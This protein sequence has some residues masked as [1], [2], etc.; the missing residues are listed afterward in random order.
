MGG[1]V[2]AEGAHAARIVPDGLQGDAEGRAREIQHEGIAQHGDRERQK[3]K[4]NWPA[5]VDAEYPW[6]QDAGKSRMAVEERVVLQRQIEE[7]HGDGDGDH[8]GVDAR[9]AH[10]DQ[11]DQRG[12][13]GAAGD[14]ERHG[15]PPRPHQAEI[16]AVAADDG[17]HVAGHAGDRHLRQGNHAAIAAEKHQRQR[18]H[19]EKQGL[20]ADLEGP[21]IG[22]H[23]RVDHQ[24]HRRDPIGQHRAQPERQRARG[25]F[26]DRAHAR[27]RMPCGRIASTATMMRKV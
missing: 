25:A 7:R 23:Q 15:G 8:D 3:I 20:P 14:G 9:G 17:D 1:H 27:P 11:A 10:G 4:W 12:H 18:D 2:E 5:P 6:R 16:Q 22:H 13:D 24:Q 19:A 26:G 21:E